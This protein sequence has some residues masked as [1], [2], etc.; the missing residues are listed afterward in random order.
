MWYSKNTFHAT[1]FLQLIQKWK[2]ELDSEDYVGTSLM[3]LSKAYDCLSHDLLISKLEAC[4]LHV[5][6][7]NFLFDYLSLRKDTTKVSSS[8]SKYSQV[9]RGIPQG[10]LLGHKAQYCLLHSP[11]VF[12]FS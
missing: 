2:A 1:S 6:S 11:M 9:S 7:L 5:G 10:S 3:D 12:Y 4:G 8:F